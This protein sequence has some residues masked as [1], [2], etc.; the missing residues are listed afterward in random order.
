MA[1]KQAKLVPESKFKKSWDKAR[2]SLKVSPKKN[3]LR[4]VVPSTT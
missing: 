3:K 2:N 4:F 1:K